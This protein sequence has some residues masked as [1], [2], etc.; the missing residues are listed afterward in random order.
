[1]ASIQFLGTAGG[2]FAVLSQIRQSGGL[3]LED[4]EVNIMI[5]PGP[6][7]LVRCVEQRK[8]LKKLNAV[9][10][11]HRHLDHY[12]DAEIIIEGMTGGMKQRRG[13][14]V[15]PA[16]TLPCISEYHR[17]FVK[18]SA[19]KP[20]QE[21][22]IGHVGIKA[23]PTYLHDDALGFRFE[24]KDGT[25][26]YTSDT[27]FSK[28]LIPNYKDSEVLV[29]NVLCPNEYRMKKHLC[30]E[31]ATHIIR[32]AK[33]GKAVMQHFGFM[34]LKQDLDAIAREIT[35]KTGVETIAAKDNITIEL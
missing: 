21:M 34:L 19:L 4:R 32:E 30:V 20:G 33:P 12:N 3:W 28:E 22:K 26:T 31:D 29:L 5:D 7:S 6:G 18:V 27:G 35:Q 25:I 14:L 13:L 23:L 9:L 17:D 24:T 1:M 16:H 10:V 2:R 15:A 8:Q 11:S